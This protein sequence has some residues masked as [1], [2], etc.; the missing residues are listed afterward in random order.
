V[1]GH[2]SDKTVE[3]AKKFPVKVLYEIIAQEG[4]VARLVWIMLWAICSIYRRRL[5]TR[6]GLA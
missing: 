5:H 2:S 1:D 4:V 6:E 3:N